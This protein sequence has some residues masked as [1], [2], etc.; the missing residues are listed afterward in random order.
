VG[1]LHYGAKQGGGGKGL[2]SVDAASVKE[3]F[4][5]WFKEIF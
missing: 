3:R 5:S 4:L 2:L 1:L